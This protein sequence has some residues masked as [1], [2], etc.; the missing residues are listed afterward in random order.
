MNASIT[1]HS[2]GL[3]LEGEIKLIGNPLSNFKG[4]IKKG[5]RVVLWG[6]S[7]KRAT[8]CVFTE[9]VDVALGETA[10]CE[11][12]ILSSQ[13][14]DKEIIVNEIY[15]IGNPGIKLAEFKVIKIKGNWEGKVP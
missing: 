11:I 7:E 4:P 3:I 13:S 10:K 9:D 8:S 6:E 2:M 15:P 12:V 14:I 5:L 1:N